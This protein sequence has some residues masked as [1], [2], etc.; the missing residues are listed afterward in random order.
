MVIVILAVILA[1]AIAFGVVTLLVGKKKT[2]EGTVVK[3]DYRNLYTLGKIITPFSI[4]AMAVMF[5][6]QIPFYIGLPFLIIGLTYLIVGRVNI[7]K[8]KGG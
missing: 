1:I 2:K 5:A 4:V 3:T 6:F 8:W 7:N